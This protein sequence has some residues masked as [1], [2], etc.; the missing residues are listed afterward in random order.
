VSLTSKLAEL[1]SIEHV[2]KTEKYLARYIENFFKDLGVLNTDDTMLNMC[3]ELQLLIQ[4]SA[5]F[6]KVFK[7]FD[8]PEA[9][10]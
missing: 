8:D 4:F 2:I 7:H 9:N 6:D 1:G 10:V 5:D 3:K